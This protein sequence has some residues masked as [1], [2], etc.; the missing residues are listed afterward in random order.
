MLHVSNAYFSRT[1]TT[2]QLTVHDQLDVVSSVVTATPRKN[3]PVE[4]RA[5]LIQ[6]DNH[7]KVVGEEFY[8]LS[9]MYVEFTNQSTGAVQTVEMQAVPDGNGM[10]ASYTPTDEGEYTTVVRMKSHRE[11]VTRSGEKLGFSIQDRPITKQF[12][13]KDHESSGLM[14]GLFKHYWA[15]SIIEL[16]GDT[17]FYDPDGDSY[18]LEADLTRGEG[19]YTL[20]DNIFSY[21]AS[22][23]QTMEVTLTARDYSGN[24]AV[25]TIQIRVLSIVEVILLT[26]LLVLLVVFAIAALVWVI[27]WCITRSRKLKGVVRMDV[28]LNGERLEEAFKK[29]LDELQIGRFYIPLEN[30]KVESL[31]DDE[32]LRPRTDL[33][34]GTF[35]DEKISF[36]R[37]LYACAQS[38]RAS[39]GGEDGI[40]QYLKSCG[41]A[42]DKTSGI[43]G[44]KKGMRFGIRNVSNEPSMEKAFVEDRKRNDR[45]SCVVYIPADSVA[46]ERLATKLGTPIGGIKVVLRYY[47]AK[48]QPQPKVRKTKKTKSASAEPE[49]KEAA[50]NVE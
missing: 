31:A 3:R 6:Q 21:T 16:A 20:F 49:E 39:R 8:R 24:A 22:G 14:E 35:L 2:R 45:E 50:L 26:V 34:H 25:T 1:S 17:F 7:D 48:E 28:S 10:T 44:Q 18:R 15:G 27:R 43:V 41:T 19:E 9:G 13:V 4:V 42:P 30:P 36:N 33:I 11:N 5:Y 29:Q 37:M 40:Y 47:P 38:Y 46:N 12:G 23:K 32:R